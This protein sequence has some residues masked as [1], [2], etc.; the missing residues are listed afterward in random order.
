[1]LWL[2]VLCAVAG[3][4]LYI[5]QL[6][7]WGQTTNPWYAPALATLGVG[8]VMLSLR[9]RRTVWRGLALVLALFLA[10]G[11]WWFLTSYV[12]LPSYAGPVVSGESFPDFRATRADGTPFS[13]ADLAGDRATALVFFR[14]HW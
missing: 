14:G 2:G 5:V 7:A 6:M 8:L 4:P 3:P 1:M 12:R 13:R 10:A 11:D 9:R